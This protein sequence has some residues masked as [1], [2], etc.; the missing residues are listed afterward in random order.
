MKS[1]SNK[2]QQ[3]AAVGTKVGPGEED[4]IGHRTNSI[5][6]PELLK[7]DGFEN[8]VYK[9]EKPEDVIRNFMVTEF[10]GNHILAGLMV[11][12]TGRVKKPRVEQEVYIKEE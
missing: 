10:V 4:S 7:Q 9:Y 6:Q 1:E 3:K 8:D 12:N 5:D 2:T 11:T